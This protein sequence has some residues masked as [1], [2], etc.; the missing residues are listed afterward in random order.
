MQIT[1]MKYAAGFALLAVVLAVG[2]YF[3]GPRSALKG[4]PPL[5]SLTSSNFERFKSEFNNASD[6]ARLVLL[7]SPT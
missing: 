3:W 1:K 6:R 5:T 2:W 7:L 4:Q